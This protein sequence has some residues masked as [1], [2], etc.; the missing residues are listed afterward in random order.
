MPDSRF[1]RLSLHRS[2]VR[3]RSEHPRV[4]WYEGHAEALPL[5][6]ASVDGIICT[7]ALHH[8]T[9]VSASIRRCV[10][11]L[12]MGQLF[13]S[14]L[15]RG[16]ENV[17]GSMTTSQ[18]SNEMHNN[19]FP[20]LK[21]W[22]HCLPDGGQWLTMIHHFP[23]P[24]DLQDNFCAANWRDPARYLDPAVQ[25]G[26]SSFAYADPESVRKGLSV[27]QQDIADGRWQQQYGYLLEKNEFDAGY[28]FL[29]VRSGEEINMVPMI[30]HC[31]EQDLPVQFICSI[32]NSMKAKRTPL[33]R[34]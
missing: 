1:V 30:R 26:I 11:W 23:L 7:L 14:H 22:R 9:D 29:V 8:F 5:P 31:K 18:Y 20:Q 24:D 27:L 10:V 28:R 12:A 17:S 13:C 16:R 2:C 4:E 32:S 15:I 3:K 33:C 19:H 25:A 21:R 6:D 34:R